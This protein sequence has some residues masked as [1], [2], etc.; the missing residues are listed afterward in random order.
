[1]RTHRWPYGPCCSFCCGGG[2]VFVVIVIVIII[3]VVILSIGIVVV[4]DAVVHALDWMV[5]LRRILRKQFN[6]IFFTFYNLDWTKSRH[7][8]ICKA[9][10]SAEEDLLT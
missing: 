2:I 3:I 1:M 8:R 9:F 7:R 10:F 4:D 5:D 6:Y